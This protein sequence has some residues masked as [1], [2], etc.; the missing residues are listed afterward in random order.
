MC[1]HKN[2]YVQIHIVFILQISYFLEHFVLFIA[3]TRTPW[4]REL[5]EK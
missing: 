3:L 1:Q 4:Q 2:K 5:D